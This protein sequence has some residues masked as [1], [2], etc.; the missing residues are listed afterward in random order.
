M[1]ILFV[2]G[3]FAKNKRDTALGGMAG[4]IYKS[5]IGMQQRG[6]RVR[7]LAVDNVDKRWKYQNV[8]VISIKAKNGLGERQ[9]LISAFYILQREYK[10]EKEIYL[11]HKEEPIDII[12]YT[13][14]FGIGLLHFSNI[15]SAMRISSYTK[16]QLTHNYN[17][18]QKYLF[19]TV[20]YLAAKRMNYI[21]APSK[22]TAKGVQ[23]DLKKKVGVIETPFYQENI[24]WDFSLLQLKLK[25]KKYILFF[26]RMSVDKGILVIKDILYK[27]L[28]EY[29]DIC[30]VFAGD[31]WKHNGIDIENELL[32]SAREYKNRVLCLGTLPKE[33]LLPIIN[34]AE[35]VLMPSLADNFPNSCAEAMALGKIV[36]G[37]DGSSLEQFINNENNGFLTEIGSAESLYNYIK[38]VLNM[39]E[40]QKKRMSASAQRRI[41]LLDLEQYSIKMEILYC[42]IIEKTYKYH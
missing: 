4:A 5:A 37:S 29:S 18:A 31:S 2:T 19:E 34:N 6:H 32:Y 16:V 9:I 30:F 14:W 38:R 3:M 22:T 12:Q 8:E 13:G 23:K 1:N 10:I 24:E 20:E 41:K 28:K 26:G 35:M 21:Y 15:P 17:I 11:L 7:V 42:K 27:I 40:M 36:I 33:K 39:S 25:D